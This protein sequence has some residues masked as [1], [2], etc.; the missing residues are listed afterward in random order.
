MSVE[1]TVE[2]LGIEGKDREAT[3]H[4]NLDVG[5]VGDLDGNPRDAWLGP[6]LRGKT[7]ATVSKGPFSQHRAS[8]TCEIDLVNFAFPVDTYKSFKIIHGVPFFGWSS[9]IAVIPSDSCTGTR[10]ANSPRGVHHGRNQ[11][12]GR[13]QAHRISAT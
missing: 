10:V 6:D 12:I 9:W 4:Q 13:H 2:V 8:A 1:E 11:R 5:T 7:G 3:F